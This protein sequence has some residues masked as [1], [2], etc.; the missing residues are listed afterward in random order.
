MKIISTTNA[1]KHIKELVDSV[2][3]KGDVIAIGRRNKPEAIIMKFP[4]T[5]NDALSDI[6][7]VN[8]Y[9][10]SFSFLDSEPDLYTVNDLK[11]RYV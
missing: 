4:G 6:T 5:H 3:E 8:A 10:N 7:N 1:R 2:R 11:K 9:S